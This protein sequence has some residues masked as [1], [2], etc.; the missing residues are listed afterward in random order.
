MAQLREILPDLGTRTLLMGVLNATPDSFSDGG[1]HLDPNAALDRALQLMDGGA[2][3]IDVGGES[4]RPGADPVDV[5][6]ELSRVLPVID[7]L[8]SKGVGP[9]SVDTT[10]AQ[11]A[12]QALEYGAALVNDVSAL[13]FDSGMSQVVASRK[14]PCVLMHTRARPS[15]MQKG[16][17]YYEGGVVSVVRNELSQAIER[18]LRAGISRDNLIIDPGIGF[19]KTVDQNLELLRNLATLRALGC[20]LLIGTSR[21]S[22]IGAIT[23]KNTGDRAFGTAAT[24]ALAIAEG[25]DLV[26]VHDVRE[27]ADVVAIADAWI[28][29]K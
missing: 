11:V 29:A 20:P 7:R 24:V 18:A 1:A 4:T 9:I 19:G 22:F 26:R 3:L 17:L 14:V 6:T 27:M 23:G 28:R 10:K 12:L 16:T 8:V 2:D 25:A 5:E 15:V 13:G 21:K